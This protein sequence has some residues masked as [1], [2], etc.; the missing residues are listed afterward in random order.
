MTDKPSAETS[1]DAEFQRWF[2]EQDPFGTTKSARDIQREKTA[3]EKKTPPPWFLRYGPILPVLVAVF[4]I[5]GILGLAFF[6]GTR[7]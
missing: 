4:G 1:G 5:L 6:I 2:A 7:I 3:Q